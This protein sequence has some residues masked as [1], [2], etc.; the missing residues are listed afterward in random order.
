MALARLVRTSIQLILPAANWKISFDIHTRAD[1]R[2]WSR[3]EDA[4]NVAG[5]LLPFFFSFLSSLSL[6]LSRGARVIS[7]KTRANRRGMIV[8][9]SFAFAGALWQT[10]NSH[11]REQRAPQLRTI[12]L[13]FSGQNYANNGEFSETENRNSHVSRTLWILGY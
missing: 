7:E 12:L 6:S 11:D 10:R 3:F 8:D 9:L 2:V 1:R 13:S 4:K 5:S